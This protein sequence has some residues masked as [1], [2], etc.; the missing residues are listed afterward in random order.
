MKKNIFLFMLSTICCIVLAGCSEN[1]TSK[2]TDLQTQEESV[3][4]TEKES[5][6]PLPSPTATGEQENEQDRTQVCFIGNSLI[7]YGNQSNFLI[8]IAAGYGKK[9]S[10]DKITWGGAY[11]SDYVAGNFIDK[12]KLKKRLNKANIVVFQDYGGWQGAETLKSIRK[13]KKWCKKGASLY[14]YM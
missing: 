1:G 7:D 10:V 2:K 3:H 6:V 13:L 9:V 4:S 12:K 5:D 14:Y 11:L 8:D